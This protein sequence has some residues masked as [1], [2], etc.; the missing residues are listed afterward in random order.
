MNNGTSNDMLLLHV[1]QLDDGDREPLIDDV[2]KRRLLHCM[3]TD[4]L[5]SACVALFQ[6]R[7]IAEQPYHSPNK[8]SSPNRLNIPNRM[9]D[10]DRTCV[11]KNDVDVVRMRAAI[12]VL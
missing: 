12:D 2:H 9:D 3:R 11:A 1:P 5:D 8:L 4:N 10:V 7:P 6:M